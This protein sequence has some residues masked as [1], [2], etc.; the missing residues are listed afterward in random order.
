MAEI[1]I[2]ITFDAITILD[3]YKGSS[4]PKNPVGISADLVYMVT[5]QG[6]VVTGEGGGELN[7]SAQ[8]DDVLRWRE[9]ALNPEY[10][11]LLYAFTPPTGLVSAP[12]PMQSTI[13][14]AVPNAADPLQPTRQTIQDYFWQSTVLNPGNLTYHFCFM[15]V[16]RSGAELGYY[17]WDPFITITS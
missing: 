4:D 1:D 15:I 12:Q 3:T 17:A 8:T 2:Q 7:V 16:D 9:A 14:V 5:N 11:V 13:T 10:S 6:H